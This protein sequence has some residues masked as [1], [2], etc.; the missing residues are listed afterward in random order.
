[1]YN[2]AGRFRDRLLFVN[3]RIDT[4]D[5]VRSTHQLIEKTAH[6]SLFADLDKR[7]VRP[8]R[9]CTHPRDE[10]I[11]K[12]EKNDENRSFANEVGFQT[13]GRLVFDSSDR[14]KTNVSKTSVL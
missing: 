10:P 11:A 14:P 8:T 1:M 7:G 5:R 2:D 9:Q 4:V 13:D 6:F 12:I 3:R